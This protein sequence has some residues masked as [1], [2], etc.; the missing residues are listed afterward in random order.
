VKIKMKVLLLL[1][2]ELC[3][4]TLLTGC[5]FGDQQDFFEKLIPANSAAV[6]TTATNTSPGVGGSSPTSPIL[7]IA[8][9]TPTPNAVCNPLSQNGGSTTNATNGLKAKMYYATASDQQAHSFTQVSDYFKY[10]HLDSADFYFNDI[11]V[12][13]REFSAGFELENGQLLTDGQGNVLY[14]NFAFDIKGVIKLPAGMANKR[15]QFATMSDDGSNLL[16]TPT[17]SS[18]SA[19][20]VANDGTH[21]SLL[22]CGTAPVQLSSST[23]VPME[24]QYYQGPRYQIALILL[25]REWDENDPSFQ[26]ED[27]QCGKSGNSYFFDPTQTPSTPQTPWLDVLSRWQ[28]VPSDVFQVDSAGTAN[29][30]NQ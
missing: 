14:E 9:P 25:W 22:K 21:P 20:N 10:G 30:C 29:P 27:P 15:V 19:I 28:V 23:A 13:T 1:A 7:T 8:S 2:Q 26:P 6:S 16:I 5:I 24:L 17:G 11:D 18:Q 12:P 3:L 4:A